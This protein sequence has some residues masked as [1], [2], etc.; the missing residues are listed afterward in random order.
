MIPGVLV[1]SLLALPAPLQLALESEP[2]WFDPRP[3]RSALE[4]EARRFAQAWSNG[5]VQTLAGAFHPK[6]IRL[7]LPD[8]AHMRIQPRQAQ[9]AIR[10]F[11][12]R[13]PGGDAR[14]TRVSLAGGDPH[15]G[16]AEIRWRARAQGIGEPV[17][18]TIFVAFSLESGGWRVTEIR[19]FL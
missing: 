13:H 15:K 8:E 14:V 17:L 18:F 12:Q 3:P 5:D 16:F 19:V 2:G 4:A 7:N 11:L 10:S 1:L 9:A 6:G